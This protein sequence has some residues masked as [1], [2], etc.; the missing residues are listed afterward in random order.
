MGGGWST[1]LDLDGLGWLHRTAVVLAIVTGVLHVYAG[2]V[3]AR[4]PLVIA[5]LG[6]LG[7]VVVFLAGYRSRRLYLTAIAYTAIQ[8]VAWAVVNA[9][10]YTLVGY[11]DKVVQLALVAVLAALA[12]RG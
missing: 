4:L 10:A 12:R 2:A 7:G 5:G 3:D 11:A 6:F 8:L 9:G 1:R